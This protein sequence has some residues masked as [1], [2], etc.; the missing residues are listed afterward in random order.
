VSV[1]SVNLLGTVFGVLLSLS[2]ILIRH[3]LKDHHFLVWNSI[4]RLVLK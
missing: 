1:G 4:I 3:N 2:L